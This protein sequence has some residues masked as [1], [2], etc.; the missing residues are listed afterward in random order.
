MVKLSKAISTVIIEEYGEKEFLKRVADPFWFQAFGNVLGFDWHS[1]GLTTTVCGALKIALKQAG[2]G[3]YVA[4]GKGKTSMRTPMD[5]QKIG[6]GL[7]LSEEKINDLIYSSKLAAKVDNAVLQ[8]GHQLYHHCF[9]ISERGRWA[10]VQQGL[11]TFTRTAR[12]YHWLSG[13]KSFVDEPR[14]GIIADMRHRAVIDMSAKESRETRKASVDLVKEGPKKVNDYLNELRKEYKKSL[15]K[16]FKLPQRGGMKKV[17]IK[18]EEEILKMP[19]RFNWAAMQNAFEIQPKNYEELVALKGMGPASLRALA[20]ISHIIFGSKLSWRDPAR[21]SFAH[22]GKDGIPYPVNR[23]IYDRSITL[24]E[25]GIAESE[26]GQ[27]EKL[28]AIKRLKDF[29][30]I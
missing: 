26:L 30:E 27:K 12:R 20:L 8:D 18:V 6:D 23:K 7:S 2:L 10:V 14:E 29:L 21:Y 19:R 16:F 24:L 9:F 3:V 28:Q 17:E 4:G 25:A 5:I 22:G 15:W 1:S 11:N 13:I